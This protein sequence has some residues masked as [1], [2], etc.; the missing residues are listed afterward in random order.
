MGKLLDQIK[1]DAKQ[2]LKNGQKEKAEI[3]RYL[4]SIIQTR[5]VELGPEFSR[6]DT[7]EVLQ[8]E[9]KQKK[10]SLEAFKKA[11]REALVKREKK[12]ISLLKDYL[13]EMMN[14]GEIKQ[15][16]KQMVEEEEIKD[17]GQVMGKVMAQIEGRAEGKK[18]A[19]VVKQVLNNENRD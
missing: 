9:L 4:G 14:E 8:K 16:V 11:G 5:K 13:P 15:I 7:L 19:E 18:V 12:E 6:Q 17:F 3:L 2:A 1:Q 10:E